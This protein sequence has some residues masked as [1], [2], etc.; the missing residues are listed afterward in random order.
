[1]TVVALE[2][3]LL[4]S[5]TA[6]VTAPA[7]I[8]S[9]C[10]FRVAVAPGFSVIGN[11]TPDIVKPDPPI[12]PALMVSAEVPDE[13]SVTVCVTGVFRFTL[14]NA[15]VVALTFNAGPLAFSCRANVFVTPPAAAV[16]VAVVAVVTAVAVAVNEAV[17]ALAATVTE[18]GTVTALL[19]L[20]SV[21]ASPPV[22]AGAL[23]VT[24]QASVV[25]PVSD[26]FVHETALS[27]PG[28]AVPVPVRVTT[29]VAPV[30]A[31]LV[32]V[33]DPLDAPTL[34]GS[35]VT[36]SVT[37]CPGFSVDGKLPPVIVKSA[38]ASV[39]ESMLSGAVPD[40]VRVTVC[41]AEVSTC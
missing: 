36:V 12:V 5:V 16:S 1:M 28:A 39:A 23:S 18:A 40:D 3:S 8:G 31:L 22:P 34:L 21:I 14:P 29:L 19:L 35:N 27:T 7:A 37:A 26:A 6:P 2:E 20:E 38:P 33:M 30:P 11:V 24:V 15:T 9:N 10:R 4:V 32:I 41:V 17:D 25:A 13:V